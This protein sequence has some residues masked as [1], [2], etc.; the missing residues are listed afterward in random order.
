MF[1]G[2]I[3]AVKLEKLFFSEIPS[4]YSSVE[5][6]DKWCMEKIENALLKKNPRMQSLDSALILAQIS[7]IQKV[8]SK[9]YKSKFFSSPVYSTS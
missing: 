4:G 2:V 6:I 5:F 8:R 7:E 9:V 1:A 3:G